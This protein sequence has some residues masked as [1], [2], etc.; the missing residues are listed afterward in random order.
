MYRVYRVYSGY[1]VVWYIMLK[2]QL[3]QWIVSYAP[4]DWGSRFSWVLFSFF[5]FLFFFI[6]FSPFG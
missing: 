5:L 4:L 6:R 3:V 1:S 2:V